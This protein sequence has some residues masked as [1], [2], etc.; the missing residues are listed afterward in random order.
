MISKLTV[1]A[2]DKK[3]K[4]CCHPKCKC[5]CTQ[6]KS[7]KSTKS[8]KVMKKKSRS[9]K[10]SKRIDALALRPARCLLSSMMEFQGILPKQTL[11]NFQK[12]FQKSVQTIYSKKFMRETY[13]PQV[14]SNRM[15]DWKQHRKWLSKNAEPKKDYS[16]KGKKSTCV[17]FNKLSRYKYLSKP[18]WP[19]KK[20]DNNQEIHFNQSI[21]MVSPPTMNYKITERTQH[22]ARA[23]KRFRRN[24]FN[25]DYSPAST[26]LSNALKVKCTMRTMLLAVPKQGPIE[27]NDRKETIYGVAVN[28]LTYKIKDRTL[29]LSKPKPIYEPRVK[30]DE[31]RIDIDERILSEYGVSLN[32]LKY[33]ASL[34]ILNMAMPKIPPPPPPPEIPYNDKERTKYNVV[35]DALKYKISERMQ[36]LSKPRKRK[37]KKLR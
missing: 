31:N 3:S 4:E 9:Y 10:S 19:R 7:A 20:F 27:I 33:N 28:A 11:V 32:A 12:Y 16:E 29:F 1:N 30:D 6:R 15:Y 25:Y 8:A 14:K 37:G 36:K 2:S 17:P 13:Q 18:R 21:T 22:L 26:V 24:K 5:L 23:L 34:N 35:V